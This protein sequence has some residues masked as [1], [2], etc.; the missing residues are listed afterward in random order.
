MIRVK[1][2]NHL[3]P[4]FSSTKIPEAKFLPASSAISCKLS[5]EMKETSY[6]QTIPTNDYT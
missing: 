4:S 5:S 2:T 6:R 3:W 1:I